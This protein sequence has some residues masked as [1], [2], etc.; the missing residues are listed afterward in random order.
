MRFSET[1]TFGSAGL[2]RAAHLR[3]DAV[4]LA[5]RDDARVIALWKGE[6]VADLSSGLVRL[7]R[8]PIPHRFLQDAQTPLLFLGLSESGAPLFAQDVSGVEMQLSLA[9]VPAFGSVEINRNEQLPDCVGSVD[10]RRLMAVLSP[11]DAE[12]A[13]VARAVF[14]WH[15]THQFCPAC[16]GN[17][18]IADAGWE[19]KCGTCDRRHFPRTE[20]VVIVLATYGN[21][22]LLGRSPGWPDGMYSLLAGFVEAAET[23]ESAAQREVFEESGVRLGEVSYLASQPWPFPASLMIGC[24]AEALGPDIKIDPNEIE[25]ARW[26]TKQEVLD[27]QRGAHK[28]LKP[29]RSGAIAQFLLSKWL[30]D[31]LD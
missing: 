14:E 19:R 18:T 11:D 31:C 29:A 26:F 10:L 30:A 22:V 21:S 3:K 23:V 6:P 16:G 7:S 27:A 2:D 20:P 5:S 17:T 4:Q 28:F 1:V 25:D 8:F 9:E 24:R 13:A 15:R 12:L